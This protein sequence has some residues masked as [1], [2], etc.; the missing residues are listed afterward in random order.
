MNDTT[1]LDI[2]GQIT[3]KEIKTGEVLFNE[4]NQIT[5]DALFILLKSLSTVEGNH[6]INAMSVV[7]GAA[8]YNKNITSAEVDMFDNSIT[9]QAILLEEDFDG[10]INELYL[11]SITARRNFATKTGLNILKDNNTR[12]A[13]NWKITINRN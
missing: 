8:Q 10:Y 5:P 1:D 3:I 11:T 12:L 7:V 13:V 4:S 2:R 9:F 6:G